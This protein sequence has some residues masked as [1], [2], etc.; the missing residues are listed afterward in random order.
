MS[1]NC[2]TNTAGTKLHGLGC[3][4]GSTNL[5]GVSYAPKDTFVPTCQPTLLITLRFASGDEITVGAATNGL[6]D[7]GLERVIT[8]LTRRFLQAA[9]A[10]YRVT[11]L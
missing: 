7:D 3:A 10:D 9:R 1:C 8:E 4:W 11:T 2:P 5:V 6:T